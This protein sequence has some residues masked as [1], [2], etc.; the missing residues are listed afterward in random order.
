MAKIGNWGSYLKFSTSSKKALTFR[1]LTRKGSCRTSKHN[2]IDGKPKV[3]KLGKELDRITMTI[4]LNASLG[5]KPRKAEESLWKKIGAVAPLVIGG[6][7]ICSRA[8]LVSL[9]DSYN[10]ILKRGEVYSITID[11]TFEEYN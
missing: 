10:I 5:V 1:D 7:K 8:M 11:A 4:E 3:E 2:V 6:K 9:S